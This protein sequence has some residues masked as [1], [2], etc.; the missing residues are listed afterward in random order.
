MRRATHF[1]E[2]ATFGPTANEIAGVLQL[3]IDGWLDRQ[4]AFP[5]SGMPDGL[6]TNQVRA[7]LFL[8][9]ASGPDQLR[10]RV[11]FALSQTIVVSA[12]KTGSGPELIPWVRLLSRHAFG[13]YRALLEDV[14]LSPT[15][16]KFLDM[17]YSKKASATTSANENYAREL[18][19][20]FTVG[21][22]DLNQDGSLRRDGNNEP[23]PT[24]TQTTIREVARALTGWTFPTQPGSAPASSNPQYF[25]GRMEPRS[26]NHDSGAK[27][28][29][30]TTLPAGQ[31]P[32]D[33]LRATLDV[34]FAHPN[35]PPFVAT[36]LIRSLVTSNPSPAYVERVADVFADNGSGVRGDLKAVVRAVLTDEEALRFTGLDS[37][38][39]KDPV[40]HIIGLGR[41]LGAR[42][43]DPNAFMWN[44]QNL[45]QRVLT[46]PTVFSF[47]SPLGTLPGTPSLFAPEF[48]IYPPALA[49]QRANFIYGILAGWYSSSFAV[50]LTPYTSV[51]ANA[52]TLVNKVDH[53]LM[54]GRMSA[55]LRQVLL[56]ATNA[57][58]ASNT[59]E[60]ALGAVFLAALSSEFAV[61]SDN[62]GAGIATLQLPVYV[63]PTVRRRRRW[64]W[65]R[66]RRWWWSDAST[67]T[68]A[69]ASTA[70]SCAL[71][72]GESCRC[73]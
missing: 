7:R 14:T 19:Q 52:Q 32:A 60:R 2:N 16:G 66:R 59:R 62:D 48:Q 61:S 11:M 21:L 49:I 58:S 55:D 64:R 23:I 54:F 26:N 24:Y 40:L 29:F 38:R 28:F 27:T 35:V 72:A 69:S 4:I 5:E 53:A 68:G 31:S 45:S 17:A 57:I 22:W 43:I 18:L 41:A 51:A 3:G 44:F 12:T 42:V 67:R 9:M 30:G 25:V 39:L 46:A 15:M 34:V 73:R 63:P 20:L 1:L 50:D 70:N 36:R 71:G 56:T 65:W 47:Y 10:Q 37:G 13:N 8:N 6:D 33:D